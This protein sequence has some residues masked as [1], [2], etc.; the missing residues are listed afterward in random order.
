VKELLKK[1]P[2]TINNKST[3]GITAIW[4]ACSYGKLDAAIAIKESGG[5]IHSKD[6]NGASCL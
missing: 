2:K 4:T 5:D 3:L 6:N 1:K